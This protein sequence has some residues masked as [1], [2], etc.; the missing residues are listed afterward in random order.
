MLHLYPDMKQDCLIFMNKK[1]I[2]IWLSIFFGF[3]FVF[4]LMLGGPIKKIDWQ[5]MGILFLL[6]LII[7]F[8]SV[9]V[10][11]LYKLP[12]YVRNRRM[13][14]LAREF[15]LEFRKGDNSKF[16]AAKEIFNG[17]T[18]NIN[19]HYIEISDMVRMEPAVVSV[20]IRYY[21]RYFTLLR[22][23]NNS[24]EIQGLIWGFP[25]V[26]TIRKWLKA[27]EDGCDSVPL[28]GYLINFLAKLFIA[29]L[30]FVGLILAFLNFAK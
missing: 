24:Y 12:F 3:T 23:D 30:I 26:R 6:T 27:V 14:K 21:D 9:I 22:K 19:G 15:N 25:R 1:N 20:G 7:L 18:G 29:I 16:F 11:L 5:G 17:I 4:Y 2:L 10:F 13:E 28:H 8:F